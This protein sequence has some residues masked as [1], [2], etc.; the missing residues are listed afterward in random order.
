[1]SCRQAVREKYCPVGKY[2]TCSSAFACSSAAILLASA[3]RR[4]QPGVDQRLHRRQVGPAE[5]CFR[6]FERSVWL[7]TGVVM[8]SPDQPVMNMFQPP[9]SGGSLLA[10]R[11]TRVPQSITAQIDLHAKFLQQIQRHRAL[12]ALHR[13]IARRPSARSARPDSRRRAGAFPGWPD[14]ASV[15]LMIS[16]P[17][18][19]AIGVPGR[20]NADAV[21]PHLG[22]GA[23][24][25]GHEI[26][27]GDRLQDRPAAPPLCRTAD[28][29]D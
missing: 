8:S 14:Q 9:L 25:G 10:R 6:P 5:P 17:A 29:D 21:A 19:L 27:L 7:V 20:E 2:G 3:I 12:R 1:M 28:A 15:P 11:C 18:L 13:L 22:I 23:R 4:L 16:M 24:R 26:G